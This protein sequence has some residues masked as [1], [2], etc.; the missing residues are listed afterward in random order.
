MGSGMAQNL[1]KKG[2][3]LMVFDVR[4]AALEP[5]VGKG[6]KAAT[7]EEIATECDSV[8]IMVQTFSQVENV[9]KTI[10]DKVD[11]KK[12]LT[13]AIMSTISPKQVKEI[14]A[15][16]LSKKIDVFDAPVSGTT[17]KIPPGDFEAV[18]RIIFRVGLIGQ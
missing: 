6:A 5:V 9:L 8:V 18:S 3:H 17:G 4:A 12:D 13:V 10:A 11:Q 14:A 15:R 2:F 1:S 7:L 16:Y